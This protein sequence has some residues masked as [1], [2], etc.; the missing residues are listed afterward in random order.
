MIL[1]KIGKLIKNTGPRH[2]TRTYAI[3]VFTV[4][5]HIAGSYRCLSYVIQAVTA[6]F[7][8]VFKNRVSPV[9]V[10]LAYIDWSRKSKSNISLI[11]FGKQ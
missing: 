11:S 10:D 8:S 4:V 3:R 5:I 1:S 9:A 2:P 6:Q 7:K